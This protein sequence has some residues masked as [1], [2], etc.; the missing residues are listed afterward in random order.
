MDKEIFDE[1]NNIADSFWKDKKILNHDEIQ[2]QSAYL[3][4]YAFTKDFES[5]LKNFLKNRKFDIQTD[6]PTIN[7]VLGIDP[8]RDFVKAC[9][10]FLE[11]VTIAKSNGLF[12]D[13]QITNELKD[14]KEKYSRL[15]NI[16]NQRESTISQQQNI[17]RTYTT[18]IE[19]A[20]KAFPDIGQYFG[21][22]ES[23]VEK[24]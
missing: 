7:Q 8:L 23:E 5:A 1:L 16:L 22:S 21:V 20:L 11:M 3:N 15:E 6:D 9:D 10:K 24:E 17:I 19:N 2:K 4:G 18:Q 12:I 13:I 14:C